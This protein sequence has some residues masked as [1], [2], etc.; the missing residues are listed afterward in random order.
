MP[1][2]TQLEV[3]AHGV[4][5]VLA[6]WLGLTVTV[7]S[8]PRPGAA[9]FGVL[10]G[11]LVA[12]SSSIIVQ[13]LTVSGVVNE[14]AHRL[15]VVCAYLLV[16]VVL[17]VSLA[18]TVESR[19][20][21]MQQA[22]L[23]VAYAVTVVVTVLSVV[24]PAWEPRVADPAQPEV[25]GI[26]GAVVGWTWIAFRVVVF[27]AAAGWIM[28]ALRSTGPDP[29]RRRQLGVTLLTVV[30]A[31]AGAVARFTPPLSDSDPWIGVS[32]VAVSMVL[33]TY[34]IF[35]QGIFLSADVA[36]R[37]FR[38]S[39]VIGLGIAAYVVALVALDA[40]ARELLA[41]DLPLV[42]ALALVATIALFD[43]I[44]NRL[45][46]WIGGDGRDR[47]YE[48]LL[49]ALGQSVITA[50]RPE[51]S[52]EPALARLSRVFRLT[53]AEVVAPD[54]TT[55]ARHGRLDDPDASLRLPLR[56][57]GADHGSAVFG[58]KRSQLP[59]T[60]HEHELLG[61][62]A[63]Y[64]AAALH[65]DARE[66][67][68]AE[69]LAS[70]SAER[71]DLET[72][73]SRLH[74]ALVDPAAGGRI[75]LHVFALG[76]LRVQRGGDL[77][78]QWGGEKAGTRQA[79]ALFA[80]L[81]DRGEA[82]V[83][84]DEAIEL[85]WPD[86]DLDRADLA[87]H[88]TLSGLRRTLAPDHARR[89]GGPIVFRSDRYRLEPDVVTWSDGDAFIER[90]EIASAT[91]DADE[92]MRA[93]NEARQLYRGPYL[94]DCPFYGDSSH[95]ES[96]RELLR[97]RQVD[98]LVAI[99]ERHEARGDRGAAA[100]AFREARQHAQDDCPPADAGLARLGAT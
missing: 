3:L 81:F 58:P 66:E 30:L 89:Q 11:L 44:A 56:V 35:A 40:G 63:G 14:N 77:V 92:G 67:L 17:H 6:A 62:A 28:A 18:L 36:G 61:L 47:A 97:G 83:A 100:A 71:E 43:P 88:R 70:L 74:E 4:T 68:Q 24:N 54:G 19:R 94:D 42:S 64:L 93:L 22:T 80:F 34:A 8:R 26:P 95:V 7:R 50:E 90:L 59:F 65:L 79:E 25:L 57:G 75:G 13:R 46:A 45:R 1:L 5:V 87:F 99:G 31:I 91:A 2:S 37:A 27:L 41:V 78:R 12:W 73:G 23:A 49:R 48:R 96:R 86:V 9:V 15:E 33:A 29:A 82:G 16:P 72:R 85:I 76:P 51:D 39:V 38:Y 10:T 53:G 21:R 60:P 20:S 55:V 98:L 69:A 32:L 84:K 52:I